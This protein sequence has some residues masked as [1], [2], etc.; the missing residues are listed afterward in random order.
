VTDARAAVRARLERLTT[1]WAGERA[2]QFE[3]E[4][5]TWGDVGS[6]ARQIDGILG[7]HRVAA[8]A[9]VA[10]VMRQRPPL[11]AAEL[12]ALRAGRMALLLSP[13]LADRALA[14]DIAGTRPAV[15]VAHAT[16]WARP[17]FSES[18]A[19]AGSVGIEVDDHLEAR[20]RTV[21]D[22]P[23]SGPMSHAAVTVT[24][25]GTT[26]APKRMPVAWETFVRLGG[27]PVGRAPRSAGGAL[28]VALPLVTLG[29]LLSVTRLIFGG[30]PL[31]MMERFDV[32]VWA[33]LVKEHRPSVIGAPPPVVKMILDAGITADHFEG[34]TAYMT[35]SGAIPPDVIQEFEHR[36][37]IPV[38]LGYGATEF[39]DS[40]TGWTPALWEEFG[41]SKVGSVGRAKREAR[42][43]VVDPDT[44][45]ELAA[46]QPGLLEVDPPE[47]AV[48]L[49]SGW[50]RTSD[51]AR[52][53]SDGFL[54]IL[55]RADDVIVRG[56]FKIDVKQVE[57]A[58]LEHPSVS[59]ACAVGIPDD[60]V[61]HVPAA[62]VT[63]GAGAAAPGEPELI[64]WVRERVPAYAAPVAVRVVDAIPTTSTLKHHRAAIAELFAESQ[65][66]PS[67]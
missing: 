14:D 66:H 26:G 30:R 16:D 60:R 5:L 18:V 3:D 62:V 44:G 22:V 40:V 2:I 49:P 10:I 32:H 35:S 47:R 12:S 67:M 39:L 20:L 61:G 42:L 57:A 46:D 17:G 43:R 13:L 21:P 8:D 34:V 33:A 27:G 64:D 9:A 6:L 15:L 4:W 58:L 45:D 51:R 53:D 65:P 54:W 28:I 55:G 41:A 38:L 11:L 56:G 37:G 50:M 59:A 1:E 48:G 63:I 7:E 36:Y 25:S 31:S 23:P 24:T 29:G 19:A 52:I